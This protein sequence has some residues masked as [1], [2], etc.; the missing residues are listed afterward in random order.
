MEERAGA[1]TFQ[2]NPLTLLGKELKVGEAAPDFSVLDNDLSPIRKV[3]T[4]AIT[5][6]ASTIRIRLRLG[7]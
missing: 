1:I 7:T 6:A 4:R 2:G 3:D 5:M